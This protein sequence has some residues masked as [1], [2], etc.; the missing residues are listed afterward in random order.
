M[1][2][3]SSLGQ[4]YITA[5]SSEGRTEL[6]DTKLREP[7][8]TVQTRIAEHP[9]GREMHSDQ[10]T[11]LQPAAVDTYSGKVATEADSGRRTEKTFISRFIWL[12]VQ[13]RPCI[14]CYFVFNQFVHFLNIQIH[15]LGFR[16]LL[17]HFAFTVFLEKGPILSL[18]YFM[19]II[20]HILYF[21]I[22]NLNHNHLW[23]CTFT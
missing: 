21:I 1:S 11:R 7:D 15:S 14:S 18:E 4:V 10:P 8:S 5:T 6:L 13:H 3:S 16:A 2:N 20:I 23:V 17:R 22:S 12:T 19:T 9:G